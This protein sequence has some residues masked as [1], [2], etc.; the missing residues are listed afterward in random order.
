MPRRG[1]A[2]YLRGPRSGET[3]ESVNPG[4]LG[5]V[6]HAFGG[7]LARQTDNT[8][9]NPE[10]SSRLRGSRPA[11][12]KG[13]GRASRQCPLKR[14]GTRNYALVAEPRLIQLQH[15]AELY[16]FV[17]D[18]LQL[19]RFSGSTL[20]GARRGCRIHWVRRSKVGCAPSDVSRGDAEYQPPTAGH[21]GSCN[22]DNAG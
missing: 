19:P 2:T 11:R 22:L 3:R 14:Q 4:E 7:R 5:G 9:G 10:G 13:P 20:P 15:L 8:G 12:G 6:M 18:Y 17:R 21:A 16:F 1:F